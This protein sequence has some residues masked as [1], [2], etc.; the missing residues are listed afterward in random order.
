M[1]ETT[2]YVVLHSATGNPDHWEHVDTVTAPSSVR[3]IEQCR[4][5]AGHRDQVH[6]VAIPERHWNPKVMQRQLVEKWSLVDVE[7]A[8]ELEAEAQQKLGTS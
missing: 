4:R 6:W 5:P 2:A 7:K 8:A 3:A 1:A